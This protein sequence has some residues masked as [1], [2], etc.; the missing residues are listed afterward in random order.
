MHQAAPRALALPL[1]FQQL[2][3]LRAAERHRDQVVVERLHREQVFVAHLAVG[4]HRQLGADAAGVHEG[5]LR[6]GVFRR[7]QLRVGNHLAQRAFPGAVGL[8]RQRAGNAPNHTPG[9]RHGELF[10]LFDQRRL[11]RVFGEAGADD[12]VF[13]VGA[14]HVA[15]L[16]VQHQVD[17]R[18][19]GAVL[20]AAG[21]QPAF[22][23]AVVGAV[24]VAADDEVHRL[25]EPLHDVDDGPA[26][27]RAVVVVARRHTAFMDQH[28]DGLDALRLQLGHQF[29]H[30][31][32]F[33]AKF[34]ARHARWHHDAGCALERQADEG[35]RDALEGLDLVGGQQ[36]QAGLGVHR[37]GRQVL[38]AGALES[39]GALAA[40]GGVA[41]AALQAQ[42]LGRT[43]VEFVVAHRRHLQ[44]HQAHA[45]DGGFVAEQRTE[46]RCGAHQVTGGDEDVVGVGLAQLSHRG[47]QLFGAAGRHD[48]G[49]ARVGRILDAQAT[50]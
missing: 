17:R 18:H 21:D 47:G 42:Q 37:A 8:A 13:G 14:G 34:K 26:D 7:C 50:R 28:D 40:V 33:V 9:Q 30:G 3:H 29:I 27:A 43:F 36:R 5:D 45:F 22:D 23:A 48:N 15:C 6:T 19:D 39:G 2:D 16:R 31:V 46:Q 1:L 35:H 24:R 20:V 11:V 38:E 44:P 10:V 49:L 12:D 25:V 4:R 41:T 32:G